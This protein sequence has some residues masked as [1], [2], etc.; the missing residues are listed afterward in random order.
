MKTTQLQVEHKAGCFSAVTVTKQ[1]VPVTL[2]CVDTVRPWCAEKA[3]E[4]CLDGCNFKDVKFLTNDTSFK[5]SVK[6]DTLNGVEGYSNFMI[7]ELNKYVQTSHC[8][9]VQSDGYVVNP[10][11]WRDSFLN[12]DYIGSPWQGFR[13]LGGNGGFSLRS[14]RLLKIL[15]EQPF[16][17]QPHPEDNYICQRHGQQLLNMGIKFAAPE[18]SNW[19]SYEGRSWNGSDWQGTPNPWPGSFGFHSWLTKLPPE[20][21]RPLIFHHSGDMGDVIYSLAT[22][23]VMGGGVLWLSPENWYPFPVNCRVRANPEWAHSLSTLINLQ[24]YIWRCQFTPAYPHSTDCDLNQFRAPFKQPWSKEAF[25]SL[26]RLHLKAFQT[27]YP[28]DQPWLEVDYPLTV[29]GRDI[30]VN[31]TTRYHNDDFNLWGLIEKHHERM[32][33][34]GLPEEYQAFKIYALPVNDIPFVPTSNLADLARYIHGAKL[35]IGNQSTP[36]AIAHGLCKNVIVESWMANCNCE[37]KRPGAIYGKKGS[38]TIPKE[39]L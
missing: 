25:G 11:G 12:F 24:P 39:W 34:V 2:V 13:M 37:L 8:L 18:F 17:D 35:F 27:D 36:L 31:R 30:A 4:A 29:P 22:V 21:I 15:A 10:D 9:V 3:I 23:K 19:F 1:E 14:K 16:G 7:R 32:F 20:V 5:H 33:F 28:E 26:F 6:I 38:V